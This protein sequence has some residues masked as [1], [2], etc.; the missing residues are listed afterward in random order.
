MK[1]RVNR[2]FVCSHVGDWGV[3]DAVSINIQPDH[4]GPH[5]TP[6]DP[7]GPHRTQSDHTGPDITVHITI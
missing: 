7:I 3:E 1:L 6:P 5:R 2:G 4:T